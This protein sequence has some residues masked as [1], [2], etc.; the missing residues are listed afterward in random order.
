M[1]E[2]KPITRDEMREAHKKRFSNTFFQRLSDENNLPI[3]V[4]PLGSL[5]VNWAV[6][7]GGICNGVTQ[8]YGPPKYGK[9]SYAVSCVA[10][11]S[12]LGLKVDFFDFEGHAWPGPFYDTIMRAGGNPD[13][14]DYIR[15]FNHKDGLEQ[16]RDMIGLTHVIIVDSIGI[17]R[18]T[19]VTEMEGKDGIEHKYMAD[20]ASMI[21]DWVGAISPKLG[22]CGINPGYGP[23]RTGI[24]AINQVRS[25]FSQYGDGYRFPGGRAWEHF[26]G[27][28][29]KVWKAKLHAGDDEEREGRVAVSVVDNKTGPTKR[30]VEMKVIFSAGIDLIADTFD[31]G[32]IVGVIEKSGSHYSLN[33][34]QLGNGVARAMECIATLPKSELFAL[35]DEIQKTITDGG[36]A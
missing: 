20:Q 1:A 22:L 34:A 36:Q 7:G 14:V 11:C 23:V 28:N 2:K 31:A 3:E 4:F 13:N 30:R 15:V 24:L 12:R 26:I 25:S 27:T 29:I 21:R 16:I 10:E 33:G 19:K 17:I 9:T 8:L 32:V 6:G 35:R 5:M 18:P